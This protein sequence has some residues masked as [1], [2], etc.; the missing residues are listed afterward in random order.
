MEKNSHHSPPRLA[1]RLLASMSEYDRSFASLGD[2][3]EYYGLISRREN[4][5]KASRWYWGQ[6]LRSLPP[7]LYY[8]S[9]WRII[10][11]RNYLKIAIRNIIKHKGVSFLNVIGLS[12]GIAACILIFLY[13][14]FELSFDRFHANAGR[15]YRI[16]QE[17]A[18]LDARTAATSAPLADALINEFSEIESAARM[19]NIDESIVRLDDTG[20]LENRIIWADPQIFDIFSIDFLTGD[21]KQALVDPFSIVISET[22]AQK[23]FGREDPI[24]RVLT[25]NIRARDLEMVITGVY[26]DMPPNSHFSADL[27]VPFETQEKLFEGILSWGNNAFNTYVLL[28][29]DTDPK[30]LEG[31]FASTDFSKYSGGYTLH[32][33]FLQPMLDIHLRSRLSLGLEEKGDI[34]TVM[35][36]S[37]IALLILI[38]ACINAMNLA[39]ARAAYRVKEVG[40]RKVV[41]AQRLQIAGQFLGESLVL[42]VLAFVAALAIVLA[43]LPAF[44]AFVERQIRFD[45][46]ANLPLLGM[47]ISSVIL[48]GLLSGGYPA[49]ALSSFRPVS[50][51]R[52]AGSLRT[53]GLSLR[54]ILVVFQFA[55]SIVMIVCTLVAHNQIRLLRNRDM[56]YNRDH[57]VVLPILD[58]RLDANIETLRNELKKNPLIQ[59]VSSSSSL[60]NNVRTRLDA[61]WPGRPRD[62]KLS[63]Y[64]VDTDHEFIDLYGMK[65]VSGRNFSAGFPSDQTGAFL[66][67]ETGLKALGWENPIGKEFKLIGNRRGRIVGIVNDFHIQSLSQPIGPLAIYLKPPTQTWH[68][69]YLMI[70]IRPGDIPGTLNGIKKTLNRVAPGYPFEYSFYDDVFDQTFRSDQKMS[71]LFRTFAS[72]AILIACMGLFGLASFSTEQRTKEIGIRKVLGASVPGIVV[73]LGREFLKWILLANLIAWPIGYF[74]MNK[75]LENFAYRTRLSAEIFLISSLLALAI[76]GV[77][78]C[79]QTVGS[80]RANPVDTLRYE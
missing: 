38:I 34:K 76:A 60:L 41:G 73:L 4:C 13:V 69:R 63:F 66:I 16:G 1:R 20:F 39:T 26:R 55:V 71:S 9:K 62:D 11:L 77:T 64:T 51:F 28:H 68:R 10:M 18:Y 2:F 19:R 50:L 17:I 52:R 47:L 36:F 37:F 72:I 33:Y 12:I 30:A 67:N 65:I 35:L 78:T 22:T 3:E 57:I 29:K 44:A 46:F 8:I 59:H 32:D 15:I 40:L 70:K 5:C 42:A 80:A 45:P 21:P 6:V 54:N 31:R 27:L 56:G 53:K 24:G 79:F 48:T 49:F 58:A 61:D 25:C 23:Y 7:Y 14:Q 74:A 43:V 75:W